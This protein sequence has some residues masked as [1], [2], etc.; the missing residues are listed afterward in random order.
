MDKSTLPFGKINYAIMLAGILLLVI[1]FT[2]M[3]NDHET[4]GFGFMGITL[5]PIIVMCGFIVEIAAI[6]YKPKAKK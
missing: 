6:L 3:A 1:G 4:Y 2:I 5:G